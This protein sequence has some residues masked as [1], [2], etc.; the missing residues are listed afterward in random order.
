MRRADP[1]THHIMPTPTPA[2]TKQL[3]VHGC[4]AAGTSVHP[5]LVGNAFMSCLQC[6]HVHAWVLYDVRTVPAL[7]DSMA[8][9]PICFPPPSTNLSLLTA[10]P[11]PPPP[12]PPR[13]PPPGADPLMIMITTAIDLAVELTCQASL[14]AYPRERSRPC[15]RVATPW[16][17]HARRLYSVI[18]HNCQTGRGET[19]GISCRWNTVLR[20]LGKCPSRINSAQRQC[21]VPGVTSCHTVAGPQ[22]RLQLQLTLVLVRPIPPSPPALQPSRP[23]G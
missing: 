14:R 17:T 8:S 9:V 11:P 4:S 2:R 7:Q 22:V 16:R 5:I 19:P 18:Y 20:I 13:C 12:P 10:L 21:D 15:R 23:P 3:R 6:L 1:H